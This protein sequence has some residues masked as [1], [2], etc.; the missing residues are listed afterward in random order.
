MIVD[1]LAV[2]SAAQAVTSTAV[3]TNTYDLLTA[4]DIGE[5]KPI[6]V[7]FKVPTTFTAGGSA[8]LTIQIIT[9]AS[10]NLSSPTVI[11]QSGAIPVA[12][13]VAGYRTALR[14]PPQIGSLG[15]R[16]LG[17]QYTVATGPMTGG[18]IDA[19]MTLGIEDGVGK[20]YPSGY[21]VL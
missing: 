6:Y 8:T 11:D 15:Q 4:Q 3:S 5:G 21:A 20:N 10:A 13:L 14:I 7:D 19:R 1:N 18:A 16:Y 12:S 17:V 2:F 9:S